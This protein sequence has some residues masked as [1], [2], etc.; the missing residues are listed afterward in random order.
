M[1]YDHH[2]RVEQGQHV[3][4]IDA[5]PGIS[6]AKWSCTSCVGFPC[7]REGLVRGSRLCLR[8]PTVSPYW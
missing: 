1:N 5:K 2:G 3:D 6:R 4:W 8:R 7:F